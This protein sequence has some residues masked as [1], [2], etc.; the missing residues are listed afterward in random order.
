MSEVVKA[1]LHL[2]YYTISLNAYIKAYRGHT[3]K[4]FS[5]KST[6]YLFFVYFCFF[7]VFWFFS[8]YH[9]E[10]V[11]QALRITTLI[12]RPECEG[13]CD[14][15]TCNWVWGYVYHITISAFLSKLSSLKLHLSACL[16]IFTQGSIFLA[17]YLVLPPL[18][19]TSLVEK[20]HGPR[21]PRAQANLHNIKRKEKAWKW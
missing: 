13:M 18:W 5:C 2:V 10:E 15:H 6:W 19:H 14:T 7:F 4:Y 1:H 8:S 9:P 21:I 12:P 16:F 20:S 3:T 11:A 17:C